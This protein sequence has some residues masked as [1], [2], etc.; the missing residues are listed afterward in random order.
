MFTV[1]ALVVGEQSGA[2][3]MASKGSRQLSVRL[4]E[5]MHDRIDEA[6]RRANASRSE[7]AT[8]ALE[9][10]LEVDEV[11]REPPHVP[12]AIQN[13]LPRYDPD[14]ARVYMPA[15]RIPGVR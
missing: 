15:G 10:M 2:G 3:L 7:W 4:S 14:E 9:F 8:Q 12:Q 13:V 5:P 1:Q 11:T 6:A